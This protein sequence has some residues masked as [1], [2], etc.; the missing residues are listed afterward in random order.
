MSLE[1]KIIP[2]D[3]GDTADIVKVVDAITRAGLQRTPRIVVE[4]LV[5][6]PSEEF[7]LTQAMITVLREADTWLNASQI[8]QRILAHPTLSGPAKAAGYKP[9]GLRKGVA[10]SGQKLERQGLI[11]VD[12]SA[13]SG[14]Y[15]YKAH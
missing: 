3:L 11:D 10:G 14:L 12:K 13:G 4:Q 1:I 7:E 6:H 15:R 8:E 5:L 9:G 2:T